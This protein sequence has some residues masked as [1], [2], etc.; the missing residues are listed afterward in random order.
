[1]GT[2]APYDLKDVLKSRKYKWNDGSDGRPKSWHVDVDEELR[3][4]ELKFLRS[5]IYRRDC[6]ILTQTL[7]AAD[8]FSVRG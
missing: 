3:E 2:G 1:M 4:K 6:E 5:E 8:R 7:T